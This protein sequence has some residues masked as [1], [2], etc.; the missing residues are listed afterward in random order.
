MNDYDLI[1]L[2]CQL[3]LEVARKMA[4]ARMHMEC[5]RALTCWDA[6]PKQMDRW[7]HTQDELARLMDEAKK[8]LPF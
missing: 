1:S 4:V 3:L 7:A 5:E 6:S 2:K 8:L